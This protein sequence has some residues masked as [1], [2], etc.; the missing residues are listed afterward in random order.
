M[1][2]ALGDFPRGKSPTEH[3][4]SANPGA[5][6]QPAARRDEHPFGPLL[7]PRRHRRDG[8]SLRDRPGRPGPPPADLRR[9]GRRHA[10]DAQ[11]ARRR[12]GRAAPPALRPGRSAGSFRH[13]Q[14]PRRA[15]RPGALRRRRRCR[16]LGGRRAPQGGPHRLAR[17]GH[18]QRHPRAGGRRLRIASGA[19][20]RHA[21]RALD[22]AG[23]RRRGGRGPRPTGNLQAGRDDRGSLPSPPSSVET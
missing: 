2:V 11:V 16:A 6:L 23:G 7:V 3:T 13:R 9:G 4:T 21:H 5:R 19:P 15:P 14:G 8:G 12:D 22:G 18:S 20:S 1:T 17:R 10:G